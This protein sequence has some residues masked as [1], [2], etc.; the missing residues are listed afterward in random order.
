MKTLSHRPGSNPDVLNYVILVLYYISLAHIKFK[1]QKHQ[2]KE[3]IFTHTFL[4]HRKKMHALPKFHRTCSNGNNN[5]LVIKE[6]NGL[7]QYLRMKIT[8]SMQEESI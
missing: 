3:K 7:K 5:V 8:W 4:K 1:L 2:S 6:G